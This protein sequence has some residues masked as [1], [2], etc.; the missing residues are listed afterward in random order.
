MIR[1]YFPVFTALL[2]GVVALLSSGCEKPQIH[3]Y[4]VPKEVP[5][6]APAPA[7]TADA[8]EQRPETPPPRPEISYALPAGWK[9]G[10]GN[11]LSLANFFIKTDSG[12]ATV[13]VIDHAVPVEKSVMTCT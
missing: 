5:E 10:G 11:S 4:T 3:V 12:E 7:P 1:P 6:T 2:S 13:N 9:E 8:A